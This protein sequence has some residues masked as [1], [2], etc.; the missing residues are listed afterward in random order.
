M[1][2]SLFILNRTFYVMVVTE[3]NLYHIILLVTLLLVEKNQLMR[4]GILNTL[5][6]KDCIE[7]IL[8]SN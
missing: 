2:D 6:N 8:Q 4:F 7:S 3:Q 5:Q 1:Y